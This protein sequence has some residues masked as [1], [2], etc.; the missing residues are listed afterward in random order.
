[1]CCHRYLPQLDFCSLYCSANVVPGPLLGSADSCMLWLKATSST[2]LFGTPQLLHDRSPSKFV[3][4]FKRV[5][6]VSGAAGS[7]HGVYSD[8]HADSNNSCPF[9]CQGLSV[10]VEGFDQKMSDEKMKSNEAR[11][12]QKAAGG[13]P[14]ILEAEQVRFRH[15]RTRLCCA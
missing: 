9:A 8:L 4:L 7:D 5:V 1:M 11:S 15:H 14:M 12:N 3:S 13:K 6:P 10:D 2:R